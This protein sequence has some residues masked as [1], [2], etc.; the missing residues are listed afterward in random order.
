MPNRIPF[1][2]ATRDWA[3]HG[4][5]QTGLHSLIVHNFEHVKV[6]TQQLGHYAWIFFF[7]ILLLYS[8][9]WPHQDDD[10]RVSRSMPTEITT[11]ESTSLWGALIDRGA[12][13]GIARND[14]WIV[15][16]SNWIADVTGIAT[17]S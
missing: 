17:I 14:A 6:S 3:L 5:W 7:F 8:A 2:H 9:V 16:V 10:Q 11:H 4:L 1:S 13:G 12:N 15:S